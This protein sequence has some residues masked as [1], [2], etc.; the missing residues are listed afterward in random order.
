MRS[1]LNK[2]MPIDLVI[3]TEEPILIDMD[4]FNLLSSRSLWKI[5]V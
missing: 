2:L 5:N 4:D 3:K 1:F